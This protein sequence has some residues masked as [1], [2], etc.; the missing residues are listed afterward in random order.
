MCLHEMEQLYF[1]LLGKDIGILDKDAFFGLTLKC[2]SSFKKLFK[3]VF[4]G[5]AKKR[6]FETFSL[7]S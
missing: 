3:G 6:V 7:Q 5:Q 4:D 1:L 2:T